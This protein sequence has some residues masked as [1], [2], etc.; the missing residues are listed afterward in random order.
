L[1]LKEH[2]SLELRNCVSVSHHLPAAKGG[3]PTKKL[4]PPQ[5]AKA[6]K[7][8]YLVRNKD[9]TFVT[10]KFKRRQS[11]PTK[12]YSINSKINSLIK[13]ERRQL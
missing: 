5:Q 4:N 9:K 3:I 8:T 10:V 13:L 2:D 6:Y 11:M 12:P 7:Q 1:L